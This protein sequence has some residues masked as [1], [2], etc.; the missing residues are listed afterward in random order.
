MQHGTHDASHVLFIISPCA[1]PSSDHRSEGL[2]RTVWLRLRLSTP[3]TRR[4]QSFT[5]EEWEGIRAAFASIPVQR[6][7][8]KV[9]NEFQSLLKTATLL[10]ETSLD[11]NAA[12]DVN[13]Q[14]VQKL[15]GFID[16]NKDEHRDARYDVEFAETVK[17]TL[18]KLNETEEQEQE[19]AH[20]DAEG[21]K[22]A[23]RDADIRFTKE[24]AQAYRRANFK[25]LGRPECDLRLAAAVR[26]HSHTHL[27]AGRGSCAPFELRR[28]CCPCIRFVHGSLWGQHRQR[29][30]LPGCRCCRWRQRC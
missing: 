7:P 10:V 8:K 22:K 29:S 17:I 9:R 23:A 16:A 24:L 20:T 14:F 5:R 11:T 13:K 6:I 19:E 28:G 18:D 30:I 25:E 27:F 21:L 3:P 2:D 12:A 26:N 1:S 4:E 15:K